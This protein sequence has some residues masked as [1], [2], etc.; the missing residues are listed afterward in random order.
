MEQLC[1]KLTHLL[2]FF[3]QGSILFTYVRYGFYVVRFLHWHSFRRIVARHF[4]RKLRCLFLYEKRLVRRLLFQRPVANNKHFVNFL[5]ESVLAVLGQIDFV[6]FAL[7]GS[8]SAVRLF[9]L[10]KNLLQ[11][12]ALHFLHVDCRIK[13]FDQLLQLKYAGF[14]CSSLNAQDV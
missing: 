4:V 1:P 13:F 10:P 8:P 3:V 14:H 11:Q 6:W 5:V 12:R 7:L 9:T 2:Q